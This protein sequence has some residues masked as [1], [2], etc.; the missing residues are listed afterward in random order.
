[1]AAYDSHLYEFTQAPNS[2]G[3]YS[4]SPGEPDALPTIYVL[5]ASGRFMEAVAVADKPN[6][7]TQE[8]GKFFA[9]YADG[10]GLFGYSYAMRVNPLQLMAM[11]EN[12]AGNNTSAAAQNAGTNTTILLTNATIAGDT[13]ADWI[14][15][16]LPTGSAAKR[17]HVITAGSDPL[18][19]TYVEIY[20][21]A[22]A[23]D[24][25]I[26]ESEDSGYHEDTLSDPIGTTTSNVIFVKIYGSPG[27]FDPA[28]NA[29]VAAIWLE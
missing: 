21:D 11:A 22:E 10:S 1:M 17:V 6:A 29:Y 28:H 2:V 4:A 15:F 12:D 3:R 23:T 18:T 14:R 8:G 20:K 7:L 26:G 19:D 25:L 16:T 24:K 5:P 9:V 13:D 27:Y